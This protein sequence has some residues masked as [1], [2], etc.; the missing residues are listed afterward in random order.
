MLLGTTD[1][2]GSF[3]DFGLLAIGVAVLIMLEFDFGVPLDF[4]E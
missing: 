4:L 2:L 3:D 1:K